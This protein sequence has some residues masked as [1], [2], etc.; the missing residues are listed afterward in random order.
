MVL[1]DFSWK[2]VN[3]LRIMIGRESSYSIKIFG[4]KRSYLKVL[5]E[6]ISTYYMYVLQLIW[7]VYR[8]FVYQLA[9]IDIS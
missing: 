8:V 9:S 7:V 3:C 1:L 6:G 5:L 2:H 4:R